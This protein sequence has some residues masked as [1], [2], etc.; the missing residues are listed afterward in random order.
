MDL[1]GLGVKMELGVRILWNY[2]SW[3]V[4]PG[5]GLSLNEFKGVRG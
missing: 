3:G 5:W 4:K 1:E 2:G